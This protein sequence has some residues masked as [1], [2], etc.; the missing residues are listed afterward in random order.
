MEAQGERQRPVTVAV[1]GAGNRGTVY[2]TYGLEHPDLCKVFYFAQSA[3]INKILLYQRSKVVSVAEP[4]TITR[5]GMA[6]A[7]NIPSQ[8]TF[9]D[10]KELAQQPKLADAVVQT[11]SRLITKISNELYT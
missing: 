10:W 9:S 6:K 3:D 7:H 4:R 1:V 2:A 8:H 11:N 5:E